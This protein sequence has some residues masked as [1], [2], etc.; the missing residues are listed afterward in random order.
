MDMVTP[1]EPTVEEV[2][3]YTAEEMRA[4]VLDKLKIHRRQRPLSASQRDWFL[5]VAA[6]TRDIVVDQLDH[7]DLT[8][9]M[10]RS[11]SAS[12]ISASNSSSAACCST[13]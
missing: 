6:A 1:A 10:S 2:R 5:A 8:A 12:I 9:S 3:P 13:P 7:L 4:A 11:A